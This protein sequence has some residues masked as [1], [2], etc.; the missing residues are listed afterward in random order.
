MFSRLNHHHQS[1]VA[2]CP[3]APPTP[4]TPYDSLKARDTLLVHHRHLETLLDSVLATLTLIHGSESTTHI[5]LPYS[6]HLL[7]VFDLISRHIST[8]T[9]SLPTSLPLV[10]TPPAPPAPAAPATYAAVTDPHRVTPPTADPRCAASPTA[11]D[12]IIARRPITRHPATERPPQVIIRFDKEPTHLPL[13]LRRSPAALYDVIVAALDS[14]ALLPQM[15]ESKPFLA[16]VHW[17]K[18]GN[19]AL[20]PATEICTAKFLAGQSDIIWVAI[21]SLL[22]L[23]DDRPCP[24]FDTDERW[25]SVVFHGVPMPAPREEALQFFTHERVDKWV[26][27]SSSLGKLRECSVL[28]RPE[29]LGKK[30]SLAL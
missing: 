20:H 27:S 6:P 22:G 14:L 18:G 23:A 5:P 25:H 29:D 30:R 15:A 9:T 16:G 13:P 4:T 28:C 24:V 8:Q 26:T 3:T 10:T 21:R 17:T 7:G 1:G 2:A 11:P 12:P 19:L